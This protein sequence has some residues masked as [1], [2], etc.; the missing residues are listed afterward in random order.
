[1]VSFISTRE[2]S[3][4]PGRVMRKANAEGPQVITQNGVPAAYLVPASGNGIESDL[5]ALRRLLMSRA[6][7]A[8]QAEA[9][10]TGASELTMDE[11]DAE[12]AAARSERKARK[13]KTKQA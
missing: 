12:I 3:K 8:A 4:Q 13:Q 10:R 1:M 9:A 5:D 11:I 7:D 6:L 2:L